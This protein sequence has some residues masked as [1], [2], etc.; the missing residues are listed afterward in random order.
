MNKCALSVVLDTH[1]DVY[2]HGQ[3]KQSKQQYISRGE[4]DRGGGGRGAGARY[5]ELEI[6][7]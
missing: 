1:I 6:A 4:R 2:W 7:L 3:R 5:S